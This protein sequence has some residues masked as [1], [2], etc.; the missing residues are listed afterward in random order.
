MS[1]GKSWIPIDK[2]FRYFFPNDRPY[3][4]LEAMVSYSIDIDEGKMISV[5][6]YSRI[7]GWS[8]N[9]VRKFLKD[10][11]TPEGHPV[12]TSGTLW[13]H[14]VTFINKDLWKQKD[15]QGTHEGQLRDTSWT[16]TTNTNTNTK[17]KKRFIPP[18]PEE[19]SE[20]SKS[21]DFNLDGDHFCD[22]YQARGWKYKT[23]QPVVDW[24]ACVRTWKKNK[25]GKEREPIQL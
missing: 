3:T 14:S 4:K 18:T 24:K 7:W 6:G 16:A 22:Y 17:P 10:I 8:R 15:K 19:V 13:G 2:S 23:G 11:R 20:Y 1:N 12:D 21:I 25:F 9:K 5:N